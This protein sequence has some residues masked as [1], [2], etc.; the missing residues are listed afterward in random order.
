MEIKMMS[1]SELWCRRVRFCGNGNA[2]EV[3]RRKNSK[4]PMLGK[5]ARMTTDGDREEQGARPHV[6]RAR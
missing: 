2:G 4:F 6:R 3:K 1:K 5:R